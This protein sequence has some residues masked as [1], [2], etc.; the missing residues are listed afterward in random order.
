VGD[1][2]LATALKKMFMLHSDTHDYKEM[3]QIIIE[4]IIPFAKKA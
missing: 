3:E 1:I 4:K 2:K